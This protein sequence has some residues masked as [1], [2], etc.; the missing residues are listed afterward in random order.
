M[1]LHLLLVKN[2][3][4]FADETFVSSTFWTERIGYV[5]ALKTLE[6]MKN[7]KSWK[8][9]TNTGFKIRDKWK[10]IAKKK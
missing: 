10:K 7:E 4:R 9:I 3:M 1:Q 8:T 6:V 2:I 5:A